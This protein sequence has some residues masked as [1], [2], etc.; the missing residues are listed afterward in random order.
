MGLKLFSKESK[1]RIPKSTQQSIPIQGFY[2]NGMWKVEN[3]FSCSWRFSDIN[4]A[5]CSRDEKESMMGMYCN[6]LNSL[7][8]DVLTKITI[9]NRCLNRQEFQNTVLM[10]TAQDGLNPYRAEY[11]RM[12]L[13]KAEAGNHIMQEKYITVSIPARKLEDADS[14]FHRV[15][16]DLSMNFRQLS[17]NLVPL[18]QDARLRILR[19]FFRRKDDTQPIQFHYQQQQTRGHDV[20]DWICPD[21]MKIGSNMIELGNQVAR[22]LFLKNNGAVLD[23]SLIYRLTNFARNLM[24]SIDIVP[25]PTEQAIRKIQNIILAVETD[26]TRW[27][28][29]QNDNLNF[30]ARIPP[31]LEANRENSREVMFELTENNQ[32]M[33]LSQI[34]LIHLADDV[35]QLEQDTKTLIAI[36]REFNCDFRTLYWQQED[37]MNTALPYGLRKIQTMET[38]ITKGVGAFFPFSTQEIYHP[39]GIYYGSNVISR[40]PILCNRKNLLNGN[41]FMLGVSGS[42]KSFAAKEEI[43]SVAL[44]TQDDIIVIDPENEYGALISALGGEVI[45]ISASSAHHINAMDMVQGYGDTTSP[46]ALKSEFVMSLCDQLKTSGHISANQKSLIDRCV[47]KIYRTYLS[48][49]YKGTPPTLCDLHAQLLEQEEAEAHDL[50]LSLELFTKGSLNIFAH[51]TNVDMNRRILVYDIHNLGKQLKSVGLLVMLDALLNR[52]VQ[53]RRQGK[54]TWLY[55]DEI[56]LFFSNEY[57]ANFLSESWKRFRKYGALATGLTQ[58]IE[59]CLHSQMARTMLSNSEFLLLL[60]QSPTDRAEL[61]KLLRISEEQMQYVSDAPRGQGLIKVGQNLVPF[62]NIFPKDTALYRLMTT[63]PEDLYEEEG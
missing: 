46:I 62:I 23:D 15:H 44:N 51:Q 41:G 5:V 8:N 50:A 22:V 31:H 16:N 9:N 29:K 61:A 39:Q 24:L 20:R 49:D 37:G 55:I 25:I 27:Q 3:F 40:N 60:N 30:S 26:I 48:Q 17:S 1:W 52:V 45:E 42:G 33:F 12:L 63:K 19:D 28:R 59:D 56:Y 4:Y 13:D 43:A 57:S 38:N 53:N 6:L 34:T 2:P 10:R 14:V 21:S 18:E 7:P 32:R 54:R 35:E 11:N 58:N 47:E 36:G